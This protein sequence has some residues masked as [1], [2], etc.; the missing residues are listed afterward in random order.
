M[1]DRY[2][3]TSVRSRSNYFCRTGQRKFCGFLRFDRD[4]TQSIAI[5][6]LR[7]RRTT[8][9]KSQCNVG[10]RSLFGLFFPVSALSSVFFQ[11]TE[12]H[13]PY[14]GQFEKKQH[15]CKINLMRTHHIEF[16]LLGVYLYFKFSY[17]IPM[18]LI[19]MVAVLLYPY[20]FL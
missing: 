13:T 12:T 4:R 10:K 3:T 5:E 20:M 9:P 16:H 7:S 19:R 1:I 6:L 17:N 8:R 2:R 18:K 11:R 14:L 15:F